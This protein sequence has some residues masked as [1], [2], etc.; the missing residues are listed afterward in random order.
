MSCW[1]LRTLHGRHLLLKTLRPLLVWL[2]RHL[3][4]PRVKLPLRHLLIRLLV[5]LRIRLG[6]SLL[7]H[8]LGR[9]PLRVRLVA[10]LRY[11]WH[12]R[13]LLHGACVRICR[14]Y[15]LRHVLRC[16][17]QRCLG[18]LHGKTTGLPH[19]RHGLLNLLRHGLLCKRAR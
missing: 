15:A 3:L 10:H 5:P 9:I 4:G 6:V 1:L 18:V 12:G 14:A 13:R 17:A 11:G 7:R 2:R 16:A 8:V 19:V